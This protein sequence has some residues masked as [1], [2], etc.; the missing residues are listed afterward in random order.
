MSVPEQQEEHKILT[1]DKL[2]DMV[3]VAFK[4][5][6]V[7]M[8]DYKVVQAVAKGENFM[9]EVSR[10]DMVVRLDTSANSKELNWIVK[11]MP[12]KTELFPKHIM[13]AMKIEKKEIE[14]YKKV[15]F[16]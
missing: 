5:K 8:V 7:D 13:R 12:E 11:T 1:K 14:M 2:T 4:A 16:V 3:R 6:Q 15:F 9:A 10:C